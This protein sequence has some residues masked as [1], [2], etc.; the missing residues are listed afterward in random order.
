MAGKVQRAER[1]EAEIASGGIAL[2]WN[3]P[4]SD[5][6]RAGYSML[7]V[8]AIE[9]P[10]NPLIREVGR[11]LDERT[12][13]LLEGEK[14]ILEAVAAGLPLE[15]VFHDASVRPG[16]LSALTSARPRI[17]SRAVLE[18]LADSKTPQHLLAVARRRDLPVAEILGRPG[19]AVFVFGIQDPGNLGAIVR[20]GEAA[21]CAGIV[22]APGTAD[23]FHPRA[24]RASAGSVLRIPVSG[25]V[26]FEPFAADAKEAGRTV[27][28]AVAS[29]GENPFGSPLPASSILV[30]GS[31]GTG[32][33]AGAYRY[34][35]RRYTIPMRPPVDSLNAAVAAALLLYSAVLGRLRTED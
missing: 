6:I 13:F 21:G 2:R 18:R 22:A 33:P 4:R 29:G 20:V 30:I 35:D 15:H 16:R 1:G 24:V 7:A 32:L 26:S 5:F 3:L 11:C 19:P 9:S 10:S 8:A 27:C 23:F 31:E 34:L 25:R 14:A 12:H 28:G 17:V